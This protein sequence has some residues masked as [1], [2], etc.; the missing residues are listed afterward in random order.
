M[1][2]NNISRVSIFCG[3]FNIIILLSPSRCLL[4]ISIRNSKLLNDFNENG[5]NVV[6]TWKTH[7]VEIGEWCERALMNMTV[8]LKCH[9]AD[10]SD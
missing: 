9:A 7:L 4:N 2:M 5:H 1:S 8:D 6:K 10:T 3:Y